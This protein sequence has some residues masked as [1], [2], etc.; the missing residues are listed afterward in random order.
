MPFGRTA[1]LAESSQRVVGINVVL[2]F[3]PIRFSLNEAL[4]SHRSF[5]IQN[6]RFEL[7]GMLHVHLTPDRPHTAGLSNTRLMLIEDNRNQPP[8]NLRTVYLT[9]CDMDEPMHRNLN[10]V[11]LFTC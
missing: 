9:K 1:V 7:S 5:E 8:P 11:T 3:S 4:F 10:V 2:A 6:V